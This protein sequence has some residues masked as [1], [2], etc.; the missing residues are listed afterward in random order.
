MLTFIVVVVAANIFLFLRIS[1]RQNPQ[2]AVL[3][4]SFQMAI[5]IF[6]LVSISHYIILALQKVNHYKYYSQFFG[7]FWLILDNFIIKD[8]VVK[9]VTNYGFLF[10]LAIVRPVINQVFPSCN[11]F[12]M[13]TSVCTLSPSGHN[14]CLTDYTLSLVI[15]FIFQQLAYFMFT[16]AERFFRR[17]KKKI[18]LN[19]PNYMLEYLLEPSSS[20]NFAFKFNH[21]IIQFGFFVLF[22]LPIPIAAILGYLSAMISSKFDMIRLLKIYQRPFATLFCKGLSTW[23]SILK[24]VVYVGIVANSIIIAFLSFWLESSVFPLF[25]TKQDQFLMLRLGFIL[26]FQNAMLLINFLINALISDIPQ[27]VQKAI[28]S[29]EYIEAMRSGIGNVYDIEK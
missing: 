27:D 11:Y 7:I 26:A 15:I 13:L 2:N 29:Q 9:F 20:A 24:L 8:Y 16:L 10:F 1:N 5:E 4:A 21:R 6:A 14:L 12:G 18:L 17:K 3:I 22:S 25:S 23:E 28:N 19:T